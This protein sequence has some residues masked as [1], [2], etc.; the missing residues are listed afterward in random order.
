MLDWEMKDFEL[1]NN[2]LDKM[3]RDLEE[4]PNEDKR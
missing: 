2:L 3:Y 1:D 4:K